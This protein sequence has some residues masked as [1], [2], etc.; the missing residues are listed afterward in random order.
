MTRQEMLDIAVAGVIGQGWLSMDTNGFCAYRGDDGRRCA[1][2]WLIP[3]QVYRPGLEGEAVDV[4]IEEDLNAMPKVRTAFQSLA[5]RYGLEYREPV[6]PALP[7]D[8]G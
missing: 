7:E 4:L 6:A 1:I 8:R 5:K 3:D 2:G